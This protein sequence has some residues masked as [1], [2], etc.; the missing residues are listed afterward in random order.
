MVLPLVPSVV[1]SFGRKPSRWWHPWQGSRWGI[2]HHRSDVM[3]NSIS[4]GLFWGIL[5]RQK[6]LNIMSPDPLASKT[7]KTYHILYI[8]NQLHEC[9]CKKAALAVAGS[10][11]CGHL[12]HLHGLRGCG[13]DVGLAAV[14]GPRGCK[15]S[16]WPC[17]STTKN[18]TGM[19]SYQFLQE[20]LHEWKI[21]TKM[22]G[23][24]NDAFE[25][26][27]K[28]R[29]Q[30]ESIQILLGHGFVCWA[31]PLPGPGEQLDLFWAGLAFHWRWLSKAFSC[32]ILLWNMAVTG[33][34]I[35]AINTIKCQVCNLQ[36]TSNS[37]GGALQALRMVPGRILWNRWEGGSPR[38]D[39][40]RLLYK[41]VINPLKFD[42]GIL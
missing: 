38:C 9:S 1:Q 8:H 10:Q 7:Y 17:N 33:T 41:M 23:S 4:G 32:C 34:R 20:E 22:V 14:F 13:M 30:R 15:K 16:E 12:Q 35:S 28:S 42:I 5:N 31:S 37:V 21:L 19:L 3:G 25:T 18:S 36:R 26:L 39:L 2:Q 29:A 11:E 27:L 40:F 24:S 6:K